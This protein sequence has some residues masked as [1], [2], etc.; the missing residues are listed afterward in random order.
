MKA[1]LF[2]PIQKTLLSLLGHTLFSLPFSP[3]P[4]TDWSAV[5]RES[6]M[7]SVVICAFHDYKELPIGDEER[8]NIRE[9]IK[10]VTNHNI[11][12]IQN[13]VKLHRL[14]S[15]NGIPYCM[16][17]G[18][19]SAHYYQNPLMRN[20]GDVD[21]YVHPDDLEKAESILLSKGFQRKD[22]NHDYHIAYSKGKA[23]IEM[24]YKPISSPGG[25]IG[26]VFDE[27]W[28]DIREESALVND[29]FG[30]YHLPSVFHHGFVMLSHLQGHLVCEGVGLR[31]FCDW[32]VF[33]NSFSN[34]EFKEIFEKKLKRV[35]LWRLAQVLS[36]GAVECLGMPHKDWMGDDRDTA[37]R[38]LEDIMIG[39]NFGRKDNQRKY[40]GYFISSSDEKSVKGNRILK[41]FG[42]LNRRV[43]HYWRAPRK[44]PILYPFGWLYL[45]LRLIIRM[46]TGKRKIRFASAYKQGGKRQELYRKIRLFEPE[47]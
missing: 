25:E 39:G 22:G 46:I 23:K 9:F 8:E 20:M 31:H 6:R 40:E 43:D 30:A 1:L 29:A 13:H 44:C 4:D 35:G 33:A 19:A 3:D 47:E 11:F 5:F 16:L 38:L 34:E 26:K 27:Y 18:V 17:K 10:L 2:D 32:A 21:F 15:E 12:C 14:M 37:V 45:S 28:A 24:H 36:L 41:A 42:A 7:Q